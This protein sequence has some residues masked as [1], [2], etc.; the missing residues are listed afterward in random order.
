MVPEG[1]VAL[2]PVGTAPGLVVPADGQVVVVLPGPAARAP[3]E[4]GAGDRTEPF[5]GRRRGR[6]RLSQR[7]LRLFGIPESELAETLRVAE[8]RDRPSQLEITTCLRR[9]E[10]EV[11]IRNEPR[12]RRPREALVDLLAERHADTLFSTR[13]Q[14]RSTSWSPSCCRDVASRSGSRAPAGCW[15]RG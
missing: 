6:D 5:A 15:R 11:S 13:R 12:A 14:R 7:M 4:L 10:L 8:E 3:G 1:A 9:G 2:D